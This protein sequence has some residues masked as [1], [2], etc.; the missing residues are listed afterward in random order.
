MRVPPGDCARTPAAREPPTS[1]RGFLA[2]LDVYRGQGT[3]K[4]RSGVEW[5]LDRIRRG[6]CRHGLA[7]GSTAQDLRDVLVEGRSGFL[8]VSPPWDMPK[9]EASKRRLTWRNGACVTL[10]SGEEPDRCRG[11]N[12]DTLLA[13]GLPHWSYARQTWD[14]AMMALRVGSDPRAMIC[15]TPKR[16]EVLVRILGE[17]TTIKTS[18][19]TF[20]N[21]L[22]LA[23]QFIDE[24]VSLYQGDPVRATGDQGPA[25]RF[26]RRALVL[27][28]R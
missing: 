4:S 15:T 10:L 11:G 22:H 7:I 26:G 9:Y 14:L 12:Y 20:A 3:G 21:K 19:T 27:A 1:T 13:D 17:P 28:L 16:N 23:P 2:H 24:I 18:E 6:V 8:S 25:A 5:L